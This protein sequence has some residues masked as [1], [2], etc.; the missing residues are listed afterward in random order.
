MNMLVSFFSWMM[1]E[2]YRLVPNHWLDIVL[3]TFA[4]K[5]F[6][7]PLSLWCH[8]NSLTMV[9]LMPE[10]NQIKAKYFGDKERIDEECLKLFK[11]HHYHPMLTLLP[12]GIQI[13][14]LMG[15]VKVIYNIAD[16]LPGSLLARIPVQDGG[17]AWIMP[18]CAGAAAW[19]L[20]WSQNHINPLQHEQSRRQQIVTNGISIGISLSLGCFVGMGV[21]L[22]WACS[23]L[24]SV[25]V[26]LVANAVMRPSRYIDYPALEASK[27]ELAQLEQLGK[28][29]V[30]RED[31][32]R[33]QRDCKRFFPIANK[34]LVFYSESSGFYKYY[35]ATI[36]WL[37]EHS[38]LV[39]HYVTNDP[40][41][42]IF[43]L[44]E[45][46][47]R[48]KPYYVG[49]VKI[50][51]LMMKMDAD[52]VVMTTP[53]L[54]RYQIKRSYVRKDVEYVYLPHGMTSVQM[55]VREKAHANF[56]AILCGGPNQIEEHRA[57]EKLYGSRAKELP[58]CGYGLLDDLIA[59]FETMPKEPHPKPVVLIAP[60]HQ[61]DNLM[62]SCLDRLID[63]LYGHGFKIIV[64][65]HPQYKKRYPARLDA[66]VARHADRIGEDLVFETD[67]SSNTTI[68]EADVLV[69]DW[70]GIAFEY[71]FAS[72]RP[73]LSVN[74]PMKITNPNY[75]AIDLPVLDITLREEIGP[76]L[77]MDQLGN[78]GEIVR[79]LLSDR[80]K[81]RDRIEA[82]RSRTIAHIGGFG[83]ASGRYILQKLLAKKK[84][85]S[86]DRRKDA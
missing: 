86:E 31:R 56:D 15:F 10:T 21:G 47:P 83:E 18:L 35:R 2:C 65:P 58:L 14:I 76:C 22:Y 12:L 39:I 5:I 37:L 55:T 24:F 85:R 78:V 26:Q 9:S 19:F 3:F 6:Q 45:K 84:S 61:P 66:I 11:K 67:F 75:K 16:T 38:N 71:A 59:Q 82:A 17:I 73:V 8:R 42:Q 63:G 13:V 32:Q 46:E 43:G 62:D 49:P 64:R 69:C 44:A 79:G 81:W 34:H 54:D 33:E 27:K 40:K 48:I 70:S 77:E 41:D 23:N 52:M 28:T 36:A 60:S 51:P 30:S 4:T 29:T 25:L 68:L 1:D 74:T 53:D 57:L 7:F 50:I 80:E 20:G 72:L